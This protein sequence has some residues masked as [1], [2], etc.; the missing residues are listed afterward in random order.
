[1]SLKKTY[2]LSK[3]LQNLLS[4]P[5]VICRPLSV[6]NLSKSIKSFNSKFFETIYAIPCYL[7][8]GQ[9]QFKLYPLCPLFKST[10]CLSN[11][12]LNSQLS[13]WLRVSARSWWTQTRTNKNVCPF[14]MLEVWKNPNL[15]LVCHIGT[16]TRM[17]VFS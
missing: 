10:N 15:H 12:R 8:M 1:L 16:L 13:K 5:F 11:K 7:S 3:L 6:H 9:D 4:N 2:N 17:C 14:L